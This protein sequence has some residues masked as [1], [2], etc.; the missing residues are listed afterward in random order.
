MSSF[1]FDTRSFDRIMYMIK[2]FSEVADGAQAERAINEYLHGEGGKF[3][4]DNIRKILPASGRTWAGKKP[5]ASKMNPFVI[6]KDNLGVI[7]STKGGYHYLYFPDDGSNTNHHYGNQQFMFKGAL[8]S[9]NEVAN[10]IADRLVKEMD[11]V[12][13]GLE[14]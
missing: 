7:V 12:L 4:R 14:E 6:Q 11:K 3:I 1:Y 2:K 5:A 13:K 9:E 10:E 8:N